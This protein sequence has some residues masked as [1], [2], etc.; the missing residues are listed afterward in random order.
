VSEDQVERILRRDDNTAGKLRC[1]FGGG[2][3]ERAAANRHRITAKASEE[4]KWF[5]IWKTLFPGERC[6]D[7]VYLSTPR[8]RETVAL[9]R[10]WDAAGPGLIS[11]ELKQRGLWSW[12]L[13]GGDDALSDLHT[14]VF[15]GMVEKYGLV[16]STSGD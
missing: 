11:D 10:F 3:T 4:E 14:S 9:R 7:S 13:K 8:E 2:R 12:E 16:P 15:K 5:R 1:E 6:P